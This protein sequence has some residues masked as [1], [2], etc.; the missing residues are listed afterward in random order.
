MKEINGDEI[1]RGEKYRLQVFLFGI[2]GVAG[3]L[4]VIYPLASAKKIVADTI[5]LEI[6]MLGAFGIPFGY[7][8]GVRRIR[9]ILKTVRLIK[10]G[11]YV[12]T[13]DELVDTYMGGHGKNSDTDDSYCQFTFRNYSE[14]TGKN[15]TVSRREYEKAKR[16]DRYYLVFVATQK[17]PIRVYSQKEYFYQ[18]EG[19]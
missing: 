15:V 3:L 14:T 19:N 10:Q 12:V 7:F 1:L 9:K 6:I 18:A 16:G 11:K 17:S 5:V 8:L 4:A 2:F 13:E